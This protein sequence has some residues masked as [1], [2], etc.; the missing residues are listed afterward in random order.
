[1]IMASAEAESQWWG[2]GGG[3][4]ELPPGKFRNLEGRKTA[5]S[6]IQLLM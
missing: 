5:P 2:G 4:E 6:L 1:M 3:E